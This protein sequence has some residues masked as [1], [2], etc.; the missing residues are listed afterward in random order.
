MTL[1]PPFLQVQC[2]VTLANK[3][4]VYV[5]GDVPLFKEKCLAEASELSEGDGLMD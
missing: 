5:D 3:L 1:P 2:A 4:Q